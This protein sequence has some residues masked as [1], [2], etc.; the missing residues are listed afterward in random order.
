MIACT[1]SATYASMDFRKRERGY[2]VPPD[3]VENRKRRRADSEDSIS[4]LDSADDNDEVGHLRINPG[5]YLTD[6]CEFPAVYTYISSS[7]CTF[8]AISLDFF[9]HHRLEF[10]TRARFLLL[11]DII[12]AEGGKG[13]FGKVLLCE[14]VR[15]THSIGESF[16]SSA[17]SAGS[18]RGRDRAADAG[19]SSRSSSGTGGVGGG[20][21]GPS[22]SRGLV[23]IKVVRRVRRYT[24]A[25]RIEAD[26]LADVMTA[27]PSGASSLC[28]RFL[29]AFTFK[30]HFCMAFEPLGPSLYDYVKANGYRPP[31]L[32]CVQSFADQLLR[33]V[34]FLHGMRLVHT[35]LKLENILLVSREPFRES[36]KVTSLRQE[37]GT[38]LTPTATDIRLIDFGGAT[39]DWEHKSSLINTRQ[40]R[41]PEVILG[42]GWSMASDV[43]SL[44]C[45]LMELYSGELLFQTVRGRLRR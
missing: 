9:E 25:A 28:V 8:N 21:G 22:S 11:A 16:V 5:E 41:A 4:S 12:V 33:A 6:R 43:W 20:S 38:V 19:R 2:E 18:L 7:S 32:Y 3:A 13:T 10:F 39:F 36:T 31:P 14:D 1:K 45:I 26:I 30:R 37:G 29:H 15:A 44:G 27:D 35:D 34:A 42:L 40:Y 24:E 23:A 17:V